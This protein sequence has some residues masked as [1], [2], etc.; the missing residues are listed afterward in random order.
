ME[1]RSQKQ[2][3][4]NPEDPPLPNEGSQES[5]QSRFSAEDL[6]QLSA[7]ISREL[8][9]RPGF[10][11]EV[12][13]Q[14]GDPRNLETAQKALEVPAGYFGYDDTNYTTNAIV[15][16]DSK[17]VTLKEFREKCKDK[18]RPVEKQW[19][20]FV[21]ESCKAMGV[22]L[23][24]VVAWLKYRLE[25][26]MQQTVRNLEAK[27]VQ[28]ETCEDL[29]NK[30][31]VK[32]LEIKP[33]DEIEIELHTLE[34]KPDEKWNDFLIRLGEVEQQLWECC[35]STSIGRYK[36]SPEAQLVRMERAINKKFAQFARMQAYRDSRPWPTTCEEL[37][38][39][40]NF[41]YPHFE[42]E[43]KSPSSLYYTAT[44]DK[45]AKSKTDSKISNDKKKEKGKGKTGERAFS[46]KDK[47][48]KDEKKRKER[49]PEAQKQWDASSE[50]FKKLTVE[51]LHKIKKW[52]AEMR[53]CAKEDKDPSED[54][55]KEAEELGMCMK[56]RQY[57]HKKNECVQ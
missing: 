54:L 21:T 6:S 48:D 12:R 2:G 42:R 51:Q 45:T 29:Y 49:S 18:T 37:T 15:K 9:L 53:G 13:M 55:V 36:C 17:M 57:G 40:L 31:C 44:S 10:V 38:A 3:S 4:E 52:H 22:K 20:E 34:Q 43:K 56:C 7:L 25:P 41:Y 26:H 14:A 28:F 47:H 1:T 30:V 23:P 32:F 5:N 8:A 27:K 16:H 35:G 24:K 39:L 33:L 46:N 19:F 11:N 50:K